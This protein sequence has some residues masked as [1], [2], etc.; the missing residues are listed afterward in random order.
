MM[1][2]VLSGTMAKLSWL[3]PKVLPCLSVTPITRK[4][5]PAELNFLVERIDVGEQLVHQVRADD[6]DASV[7]LVV[8]V[9]EVAALLDFFAADIGKAGSHRR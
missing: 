6:A 9:I 5:R 8:G 2:K 3:C 1:R 7:V 4:G